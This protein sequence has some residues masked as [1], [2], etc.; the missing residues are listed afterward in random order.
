M[1]YILYKIIFFQDLLAEVNNIETDVGDLDVIGVSTITKVDSFNGDSSP[2]KKTL[3]DTKSRYGA[4][5]ADLAELAEKQKA[6]SD[7]ANEFDEEI[8]VIERW[9]ITIFEVVK[10]W[11]DRGVGTDPD[12]IKKQLREAEVRNRVFMVVRRQGKQ[13]LL[14]SKSRLY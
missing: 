13:D 14:L 6:D 11:D 3:E 4:L 10:S 2:V 9:V 1:S 12:E 8:I 7:K 5:A